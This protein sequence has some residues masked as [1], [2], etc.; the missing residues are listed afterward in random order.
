MAGVRQLIIEGCSGKQEDNKKNNMPRN[1]D[2]AS[3][4]VKPVGEKSEVKV[5]GAAWSDPLPLT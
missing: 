2:L 1:Y 4:E 3:A 5:G